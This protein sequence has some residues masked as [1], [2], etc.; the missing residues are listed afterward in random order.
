MFLILTGVLKVYTDLKIDDILKNNNWK[1][2][3]QKWTIIKLYFRY[4]I[5]NKPY[6]K[7]YNII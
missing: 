1:Y 3:D 7:P 5:S 6:N 4:L 2:F